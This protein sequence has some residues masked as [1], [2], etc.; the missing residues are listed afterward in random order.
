MVGRRTN[1]DTQPISQ[2]QLD[3]LRTRMRDHLAATPSKHYWELGLEENLLDRFHTAAYYWSNLDAKVQAARSAATD[4]GTDTKYIFQIA[5]PAARKGDVTAFLSSDAA[6]K[7]DVLALHP[8]AWPD[9]PSPETWMADL[10]TF[11]FDQMRTTGVQLPVWFTE[12]G[13]PHAINYPGGW[14]GYGDRNS[15]DPEV[16]RQV[17]GLSRRAEVAYLIKIYVLG[18]QFGAEKVFWYNYIDHGSDRTNPENAFGIRDFW[19][20]PKPAYLGWVSTQ[21][22]DHGQ[23]AGVQQLSAGVWLATFHG[24]NGNVRVVW[25]YPRGTGTVPWKA[26]GLTSDQVIAVA[27]AVGTPLP[28]EHAGLDVGIDPIFVTSRE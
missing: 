7:F 23:P 18:R 24:E 9:F 2:A 5:E 15:P 10:M 17:T 3:G 8:Y 1:G 25:R 27:S 14:F 28:A 13:A 4:A 12:V 26:L 11:T 21:V 6:T 19:G 16:N 22:I 20:F